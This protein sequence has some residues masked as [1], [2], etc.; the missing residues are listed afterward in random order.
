MNSLHQDEI[1]K[2]ED[3]D[4]QLRYVLGGIY[5]HGGLNCDKYWGCDIRCSTSPVST[6]ENYE[7]VKIFI[8]KHNISNSTFIRLAGSYLFGTFNSYKGD[9]GTLIPEL[10]RTI[11]GYNFTHTNY[12]RIPEN[13]LKEQELLELIEREATV[14]GTN[15]NNLLTKYSLTP[16]DFII[17]AKTSIN[18]QFKIARGFVKTDLI[19]DLQEILKINNF[20]QSY[21]WLKMFRDNLQKQTLTQDKPKSLIRRMLK[22]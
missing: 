14:E 8:T 3:K 22:K 12:E 21:E 6:D 17:L 13:D 10:D 2:L 19:K 1:I 20:Y 7:K 5:P 9:W 4:L 16:I 15:L 11:M 18:Y